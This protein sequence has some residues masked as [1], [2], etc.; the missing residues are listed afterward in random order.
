MSASI[1]AMP[2][3]TSVNVTV[4]NETTLHAVLESPPVE[5]LP[6]AAIILSVV[7]ILV[8]VVIQKQTSRRWSMFSAGARVSYG[9]SRC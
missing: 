1:A 6:L 5:P 9:Q 7:T 3:M 8:T 4:G 2:N